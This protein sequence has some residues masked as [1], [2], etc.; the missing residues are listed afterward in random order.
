MQVFNANNMNNYNGFEFNKEYVV[1]QDG[2]EDQCRSRGGT[3]EQCQA[4]V[5]LLVG[6]DNK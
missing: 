3:L 4:K 5:K 1:K 6:K 2:H